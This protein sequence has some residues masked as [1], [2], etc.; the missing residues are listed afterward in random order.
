[1][2]FKT[3]HPF[4]HLHVHTEYSLLD[5]SAK[6]KE[7][8]ERVK[9]LGMN[10]IAITDHGAMYGVIDFYK[11]AKEIGIKPIIGCEVYVANGSRLEKNNKNAYQYTH[12]V[13]LAENNE[14]YQNL[15]KLVSYGFIDGFYYKPRVDKE[16]LKK[17]HKGLIASSACLAGAVARNILTV[18][19]E[20]AKQTALEYQ[21]IFGKGNYYLEL[22]D[23]NL[24][25]QKRVNEALRKIHQETGIP[26]ICS[27]DSH[28]IYKED[29]VPHDILLCIQTNKTIHDENRMRYEGGQFYVK[30]AEE[31]YALFPED[32][33]ALANTQRIADRCNVEFV[34]HDL[35]LP[36]FDV[37]EGKTAKQYLRELCYAGFAQK[38]PNASEELKKRLDYE[39]ETIE[40]MGYV[41]YFLIV[42]DFIKFSK[43]NG[44]IVGPGRDRKSVV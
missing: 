25:D 7:L 17:Y 8:V 11:A 40:T 37:P 30:S 23:H 6:I 22:Q 31:M 44:I 20:K 26:M 29:N 4:T 3:E 35:K 42:W 18:S 41:D 32:K 5:G 33:E 27:N 13:L 38:Y 15:I 36:R 10:S 34:F 9:E 2:N 21:E 14:G 19:Y 43:D 12:L 28:Y 24:Q 1:M 39:L 16:L